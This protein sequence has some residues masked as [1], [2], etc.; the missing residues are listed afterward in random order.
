ML[1]LLIFLINIHDILQAG[2][3][4]GSDRAP[5]RYKVKLKRNIYPVFDANEI[6]LS[7]YGLCDNTVLDTSVSPYEQ[8]SCLKKPALVSYRS[9]TSSIN[10]T[11]FK[12]LLCCSTEVHKNLVIIMTA[13]KGEEQ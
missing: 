2:R 7:L 11:L 12:L 8:I 6:V 9:C 3:L 4:T 13:R 1:L 10:K 5:L